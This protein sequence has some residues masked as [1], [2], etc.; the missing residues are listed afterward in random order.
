M[1]VLHRI[2]D[3]RSHPGRTGVAFFLLGSKVRL[4]WFNIKKSVAIGLKIGYNNIV[5]WQRWA[6]SMGFSTNVL[7]YIMALAK[8]TFSVSF[9]FLWTF[10]VAQNKKT[11][12]FG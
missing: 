9:P 4:F 10:Q 12:R 6:K 7:K 1:D 5:N 11:Q 3:A 8:G 2:G